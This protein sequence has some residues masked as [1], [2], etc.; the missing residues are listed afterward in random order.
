MVFSEPTPAHAPHE[1]NHHHMKP[2]ARIAVNSTQ[3]PANLRQIEQLIAQAARAVA[4]AAAAN[5][6]ADLLV[7]SAEDT[8]ASVQ[9][10]IDTHPT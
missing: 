5:A 1:L 3:V 7:H 6:I 10:L 8:F 9:A 2:H 4:G